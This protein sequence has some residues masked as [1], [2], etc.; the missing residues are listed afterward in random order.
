MFLKVI[1]GNCS[2]D[3]CEREKRENPCMMERRK[4]KNLL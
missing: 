3:T 1:G 4:K 2:P